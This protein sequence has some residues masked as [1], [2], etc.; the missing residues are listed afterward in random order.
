MDEIQTEDISIHE[1]EAF[2]E[3]ELDCM[4]PDKYTLSNYTYPDEAITDETIWDFTQDTWCY[5]TLL[6]FI[7]S[8]NYVYADECLHDFERLMW[9]AYYAVKDVDKQFAGMYYNAIEMC[10][11]LSQALVEGYN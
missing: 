1:L 5:E 10:W 2:V 6:D 8:N 9:N 11:N 3:S 7:R 4:I